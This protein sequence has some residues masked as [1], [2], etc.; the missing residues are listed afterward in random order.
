MQKYPVQNNSVLTAAIDNVCF[1]RFCH[2]HHI[3]DN[4][5]DINESNYVEKQKTHVVKQPQRLSLLK[6][7]VTTRAYRGTAF[8]PY[9]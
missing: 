4:D 8:I 5:S 1:V 7:G 6:Y 3:N 2:E 9:L